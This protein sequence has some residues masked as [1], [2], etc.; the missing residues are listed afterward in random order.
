MAELFDK[1]SI[2]DSKIHKPLAERL[3]PKTLCDVVGQDTILKPN[4]LLFNSVKINKYCSCVLVGP[5]GTGK[6]T[7]ARL[8]AVESQQNFI[9]LSAMDSGV[10]D[11][12]KIFNNARKSGQGSRGTVL[13]IDEIHRFN[14]TQQD[15]FLP[16]MENGTIRLIGATTENPNLN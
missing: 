15:S 8:I 9:E 4:G 14:K 13:F 11:L 6:T 3:R 5:P 1:L 10:S 2:R 16:H 7:I 12:R